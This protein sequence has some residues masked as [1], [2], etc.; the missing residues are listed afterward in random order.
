[1]Q[2]EIPQYLL[3]I[4]KMPWISQSI[5]IKQML[6]RAKTVSPKVNE[7]QYEQCGVTT[8]SHR[9]QNLLRNIEKR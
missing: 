5:K 2:L 9:V 3:F 7:T 8:L 4:L 1:M 6:K